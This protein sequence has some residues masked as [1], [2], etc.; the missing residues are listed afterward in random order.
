VID[1]RFTLLRL[2]ADGRFHSGDA[3]GTDLGICRSAVWKE[4]GRLRELGI[5]INALPGRGYQL[6]QPL[7]LLDRDTIIEKIGTLQRPHLYDLEIIDELDSTNC[8][9]SGRALSGAA[10]GCVVLAEH[11]TA[12][13]G[14]NGRPWISPMAQNIYM[15][16]LWRFRYSPQEL[17]GLALIFGVAIARTLSEFGIDDVHLKWPNDVVWRGRKLAGVL[18]ELVSEATGPCS[19]VIGIGLNINMDSREAARIDQT[20]VDLKSISHRPISRNQ[21]AGSLITNSLAVLV[22]F[23]QYRFNPFCE[24]WGRYDMLR[25][26]TI[27]VNSSGSVISGVAEGVADDGALLLRCNGRQRKIYS[28]EAGLVRD[29]L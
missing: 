9:M 11:Q 6:A 17:S 26:L 23:E 29:G 8:Y 10:S 7:E 24:E 3:I 5:E 16:V 15:S 22:D 1:R 25:G 12:G 18:I 14:R 28:G 19:A 13:R 4:I 2:L 27:R 21:L 20:W